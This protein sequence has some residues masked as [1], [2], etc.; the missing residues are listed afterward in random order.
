MTKHARGQVDAGAAETYDA[1]FVPALFDG[2]ADRIADVAEIGAAA[3]VVDVACGTGA[4]TRVVRTRTSGRVVGVDVNPAMVEVARRHGGDID[5]RE[6]DAV[7]LPFGDGAFDVATCQFGLM[8]YDEPRLGIAE[9]ARVSHSGVVAVW[10]S[11]ERSDGYTAMQELFRDE[12]GDDAAA[13]LDAPSPWARMVCWRSCSRRRA[14]RVCRTRASRV[15][16]GSHRSTSGSRQRSEGGHLATLSLT[17]S[18]LISLRWLEN[19]SA[20]FLRRTGASSASPRES[21]TG[22]RHEHGR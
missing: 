15:R 3:S 18:S 22:G 4:L 19:A 5:Y 1:L 8:F 17:K 20:P 14:Y 12:L 7:D 2:F 13:S 9:M 11:I 16:V 10:D 6:S 21:P